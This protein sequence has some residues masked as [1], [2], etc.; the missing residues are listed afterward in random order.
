MSPDSAVALRKSLHL[1][2]PQ[3][4]HLYNGDSKRRPRGLNKETCRLQGV[5][6]GAQREPPLKEISHRVH[7]GPGWRL[8][9]K[10]LP[11]LCPSARAF[12]LVIFNL[13]D[14]P[15]AFVWTLFGLVPSVLL[16]E[17]SEFCQALPMSWACGPR[18][19]DPEPATMPGHVPPFPPPTTKYDFA[20]TPD[21]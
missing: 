10:A 18:D 17:L 2:E 14:V 9:S 3:F 11:E 13:Q 7:L 15:F 8:P 5:L 6:P 1:S 4:Y 12:Q 16:D 21:L 19:L 20:F